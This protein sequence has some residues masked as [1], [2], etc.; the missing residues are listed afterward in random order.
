MSKPAGFPALPFLIGSTLLLALAAEARADGPVMPTGFIAEPIG[1]GWVAPTGMVFLDGT[2]LLVCEKS[3][4]VWFVENDLKK[5][6]VLDLSA[7]TLNNGDRGILGIALDPQF[8]SNGYLYLLL[9]VDPNQDGSELEQSTFSRLVRYTTSFDAGGNL[10][11]DGSSR[12]ELLGATWP[13]GIPSCH[14]SHSVGT[15]R[16]LSDGS[17]VLSH[18]DGAHYDLTDVGGHDGNCFGAGKFPSDQ[19]IGS[20]RSVYD[21]SLA[22]KILRID[23]ATGLG[24]A[25]NPFFDGNP[26]SIRSRI[27]AMGLRNPFRFTLMP[28]TGPREA[29]FISDVGWNT[30]EEVNVAFGGE[31]FGW[32][33]YEGPYP[34]PSYQSGDPYGFCAAMSGS[35]VPPLIAWHHFDPTYAGYVGNCAAGIAFYPGGAYPP[36]YSGA[37][38]FMDYGRSWLKV[39]YLDE[40][41]QLQNVVPFGTSMGFPV[42]MTI[43]PGTGNLVYISLGNP[44]SVLRIRYTAENHPPIVVATAAPAW[45]SAPLV[46]TL[47]ASQS[48]DPDQ[49]AITFLWDLGDGTSSTEPDLVKVYPDPA[50]SYHLRL[51]VTDSWGFESSKEFLVTPGNTPPSIDR[52]R[53]P[54]AGA[55]YDVGQVVFLDAE[56]SDLE[57]DAAGGAPTATW[58]I[59]L[60]HDHHVHP[61]YAIATGEHTS[62]IPDAP[63]EG[64]NFRVRLEVEDARGL[65]VE[66]PVLIYDSQTVPEAHIVGASDFTPRL[67]QSVRMTGHMELPGDLTFGAVPTLTWE[68]G[69]GTQDV[70]KGFGHQRDSTPIHLYQKA[71]TFPLKLTAQVGP[72]SST[73]QVDIRV[74]P[75]RTAVAVFVPLVAQRWISWN[76]QQA[77]AN[78]I[79]AATTA[80]DREAVLF[81]FHQ[82]DE[83]VAWMTEYMD[84]GVNDALVILDVG[85]AAVYSGQNDGS[86]AEQWLE[87]G[88][89]IVWSGF[90]PFYLYVLETGTSSSVG[91]GFFGADE[92]LDAEDGFI[93]YGS[94]LQSLQ[95]PSSQIPSLGSFSA[96]RA[97]R[98]DQ[99]GPEWSVDAVYAEDADKDSDAIAIRHVSGGVYAQFHC[100]NSAVPREAVLT[101]FVKAFFFRP[102]LRPG[103]H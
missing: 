100:T 98:Y 4:R 22:G 71:G 59:D 39:A 18:G 42:D 30:W 38:F 79:V 90:A 12:L 8:D 50:I 76:E 16:F 67:H 5:N 9:V 47:A 63:Y 61:D 78:S 26:A 64:T 41:L 51:E 52:M 36:I 37:L 53:S 19:D 81:Y 84:D 101:D 94:G 77:V 97:L 73:A 44:D 62:F 43:E 29:L 55:L 35:H 58:H 72:H 13:T 85:P 48:S 69:D 27:Y 91:A 95:P 102:H 1:S 70:F 24:L 10:L 96:S 49:D 54:L 32:P 99:L 65:S 33:C 92:V 21:Q 46:V 3:G 7:E 57:D 82:Q 68:W 103:S 40:N 20:L 6:L 45:G 15:I 25:D 86:L 2:R 93:V 89:S 80:A 88:N 66:R 23:P 28:D 75:L 34:E 60:M 83:L 11:A 31:N 14:L 74:L 87:S 17:L 56:V